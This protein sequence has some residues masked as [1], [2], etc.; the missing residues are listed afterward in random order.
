M[1]QIINSQANLDAYKAFL[2]MQFDKHHYLR[3]SMKTGEKLTLTQNSSLHLFNTNLS[4]A[5]NDANIDMKQFFKDGY[6]I[7]WTPEIVKREIWKPV[8][9][10]MFNIDST[11]KLKRKQ[12]SEV[13]DVI[14]RKVSEFGI[15]VP[16]PSK[17]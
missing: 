17:G 15:F 16:F 2:D 7:T 5:L 3:L 4:I 1:E 12:V 6:F 8:Q 13:Y 11:T 9:K 10:A 14:N